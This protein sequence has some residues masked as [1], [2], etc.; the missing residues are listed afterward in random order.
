MHDT[1]SSE[2]R[3]FAL[4]TW[5]QHSS[6]VGSVQCSKPRWV[7]R[8]SRNVCVCYWHLINLFSLSTGIRWRQGG[9]AKEW[10]REEMTRS[11]KQQAPFAS[12]IFTTRRRAT[13]R[14][15]GIYCDQWTCGRFDSCWT[16]TVQKQCK[17]NW[18]RQKW[19][20]H[21]QGFLTAIPR[22]RKRKK[23]ND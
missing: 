8:H 9:R 14:F 3:R 19:T 7:K 22:W 11:R 17:T 4:K 21:T 16:W 13:E 5:K 23:K 12:K 1:C 15:D 10:R 20:A 2:W 18:E 6:L